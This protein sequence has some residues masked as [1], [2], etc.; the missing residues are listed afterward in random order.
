M[1]LSGVSLPS[2]CTV[3]FSLEQVLEK[4]GIPCY[5][6]DGDNLRTGLN[7]NLGFSPEGLLFMMMPFILISLSSSCFESFRPH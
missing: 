3:S 2:G 6:L 7:K 5:G 4:G 1:I